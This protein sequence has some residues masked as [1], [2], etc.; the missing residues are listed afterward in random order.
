LVV[1]SWWRLPRFSR[2]HHLTVVRLG[3]LA[4]LETILTRLRRIVRQRQSFS[5]EVIVDFAISRR[6]PE[7]DVRNRGGVFARFVI[8]Q[9]MADLVDQDG[10]VLFD[11]MRGQPIVVV[12]EP[13]V[14]IH[15][16]AGDHVGLD[17]NQ[18]EERR[19]KVGALIGR[20]HARRLKRARI[21]VASTIE[22]ANQFGKSA[23]HRRSGRSRTLH[24]HTRS[25]SG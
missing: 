16:H 21:A 6:V 20:A 12:V 4:S 15:G 22:T 5:G 10:R 25:T 18:I 14:R 9:Q 2:L 24:R 1:G 19:R 7:H 11:G 13:P 23:Q 17:R 3:V 8:A